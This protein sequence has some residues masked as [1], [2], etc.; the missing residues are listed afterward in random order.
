MKDNASQMIYCNFTKS[1]TAED[2]VKSFTLLW[3]LNP[4]WRVFDHARPDPLN[5]RYIRMNP[6]TGY[7][8]NTMLRFMADHRYQIELTPRR[9]K[10]AVGIAER[11][12]GIITAKKTTLCWSG[13]PPSFW[14]WA[15]FKT[16]QDLNLN[17]RKK[18]DTSPY[19]FIT[20]RHTD[21]NSLHSFFA[22][23]YMHIP[24]KDRT[25]KLPTR[26]AQRCRFLAYSYTIILVP[27]YV[28]IIVHDNNTYGGT[29]VS[30]DIIFDES[31]VFNE[32]IDNSPTDE[33]FAA[34]HHIKNT[35]PKQASVIHWHTAHWRSGPRKSRTTQ[36]TKQSSTAGTIRARGV[37]GFGCWP[38]IA[39][40]TASTTHRRWSR[41]YQNLKSV[42]ISLDWSSIGM[43]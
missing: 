3:N 25:S 22:V 36:H 34:R 43:T 14:C 41:A 6:E 1:R 19:N 12:V 16:T 13:A 33:E 42:S 35:C 11:T 5:P 38:A 39:G 29:R 2:M 26:R 32:Y 10:H 21:I 40:R 18:I 17:Y 8:S 20:G 31:C 4:A 27:T 37:L 15:M 23:C 28:V 30:K 7:R 9:D 24:L